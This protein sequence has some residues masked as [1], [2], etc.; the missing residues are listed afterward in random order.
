MIAAAA[1]ALRVA[2]LLG[3]ASPWP[4]V[5]VGRTGA[6]FPRAV[7]LRIP[8]RDL[9]PRPRRQLAELS[10]L[11]QLSFSRRCRLLQVASAV[12]L[13]AWFWPGLDGAPIAALPALHYANFPRPRRA[14]W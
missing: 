6:A 10:L 5:G 7:D 11:W 3:A 8:A 13:S 14:C 9:R 2:W 12:E 1:T 4:M